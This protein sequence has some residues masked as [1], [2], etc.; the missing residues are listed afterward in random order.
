MVD[1]GLGIVRR[2]KS[3]GQRLKLGTGGGKFGPLGSRT[4][5]LGRPNAE[6]GQFEGGLPAKTL[7]KTDLPLWGATA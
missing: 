2:E 3:F 4:I 5:F 6:S 1:S 7:N